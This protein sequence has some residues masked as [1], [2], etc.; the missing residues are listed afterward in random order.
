MSQLFASGGQSIGASASASVLMNIQGWFPSGLTGLILQSTGLSRVFFCTTIESI[1]SLAFNLLYGPTLTSVHDYWKNHSF[2]YR[3]LGWQSDI[4]A[5]NMLSRFV[6]S[7]RPKNKC[8]LIL[9]LLCH[10]VAVHSDF[11]VQE[12]KIC[13]CFHFF[14][15]YL[16]WRDGAGCHDF[17]FFIVEF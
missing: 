6:I 9:W 16:T 10:R 3:D 11:G 5:F 17:S 13:H 12:N 7:F 2:D 14:P 4:F 8:L 15:F 1:N